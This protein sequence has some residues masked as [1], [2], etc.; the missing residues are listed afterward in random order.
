MQKL[1]DQYKV[2]ANEGFAS[3]Y[4]IESAVPALTKSKPVRWQ[5][6]ALT[7]LGA[8]VFSVL[9]SIVLEKFNEVKAN[10]A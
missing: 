1:Y 8:L 2:S 5:I 4:L 3:I 7:A 9:L 6:V 10:V